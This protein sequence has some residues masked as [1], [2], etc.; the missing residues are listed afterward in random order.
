MNKVS[1]SELILTKEGRIYHLDLRPE[2]VAD[3]IILVG[4]PDRVSL[5]KYFFEKIELERRHREF[6]ACT[7]YYRGER[8][9]VLSTGIGT[10]NIDIVC[11]EL[12]LLKNLDWQQQRFKD[13]LTKMRWLRLG[14]C[15]GLQ[16][17]VPPGTLV[18]SSY[19]I[20]LDALAFYYD[21]TPP[22]IDW[23]IIFEQFIKEHFFSPPP[24]YLTKAQGEWNVPQDI[25][26]GITLT[27]AGFY[28]PQGRN[29]GRMPVRY[30]NLPRKMQQFHYNEHRILNME[31]E[32]AAINL[33]ATLLGHDSATLCVVLANRVTGERLKDPAKSIKQLIQVGLDLLVS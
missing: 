6:H 16:A 1:E 7:G 14:T 26:K 18:F 19:A 25:K 13:S 5:F 3:N 27:A 11:T 2:E 10:D 20:G 8:I 23:A 33:F 22:A 32:A 9:T 29:V 15:G 17:D 30:H 31:M 12:D 21:Y 24:Y 28:G 4:D